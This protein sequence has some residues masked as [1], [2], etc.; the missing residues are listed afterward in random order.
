MSNG[1][2]ENGL[3]EL[4][5]RLWAAADQL[6][7]NSSLRPAEYSAP[8]MGLRKEVR[9]QLSSPLLGETI[10]AMVE[11]LFGD[12]AKVLAALRGPEPLDTKPPETSV[13]GED[14]GWADR[15][16]SGPAREYARSRACTSFGARL[17]SRREHKRN[18]RAKGERSS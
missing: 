11:P 18:G 3:A 14:T 4:E 13:K 8:V 12:T 15:W 5:R 10:Q 2:N 17:G 6:W 16:N 1:R 7:A 9:P